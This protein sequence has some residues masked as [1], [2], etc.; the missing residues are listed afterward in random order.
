MCREVKSQPNRF[1]FEQL[2]QRID[3]QAIFA[4]KIYNLGHDRFT[5]EHRRL[6]AFEKGDS[7]F[8]IWIPTIQIRQER[9]G[10]TDGDHG[11]RN[12]ARALVADNRLPARL[13]ARSAVIA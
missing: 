9:A 6:H 8:V 7:P 13:P 4:Q 12:L 2:K 3:S 11:R 10:V 1:A 5:D